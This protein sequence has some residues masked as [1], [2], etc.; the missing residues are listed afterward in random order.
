MK[1]HSQE[2]AEEAHE[3]HEVLQPVSGPQSFR[4]PTEKAEAQGCRATANKSE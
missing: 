2:M 1:A 4:K 3:G